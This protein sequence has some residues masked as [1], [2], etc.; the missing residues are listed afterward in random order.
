MICGKLD[1]LWREYEVLK[2][3]KER[4]QSKAREWMKVA[5]KMKVHTEL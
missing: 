5:T 1:R 4:E 3:E 2:K